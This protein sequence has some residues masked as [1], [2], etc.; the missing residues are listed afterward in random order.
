MP[1]EKDNF[2]VNLFLPGNGFLKDWLG[3]DTG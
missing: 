2:R 1:R 3:N